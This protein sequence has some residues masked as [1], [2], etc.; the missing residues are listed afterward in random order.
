MGFKRMNQ[1]EER[2]RGDMRKGKARKL[3]ADVGSV[4]IN[5]IH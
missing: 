3:E 5:D 2:E 4:E 1:F